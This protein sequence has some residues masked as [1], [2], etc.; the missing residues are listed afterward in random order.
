MRDL[1]ARIGRENSVERVY[2][3]RVLD[4]LPAARER[5]NRFINV[6]VAKSFRL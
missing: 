5:G 1:G 4:F 6:D 3:D 2:S